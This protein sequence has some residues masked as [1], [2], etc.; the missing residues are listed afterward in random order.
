MITP[1]PIRSGQEQELLQGAVVGLQEEQF[2]LEGFVGIQ[3]SAWKC[4]VFSTSAK[5]IN[6]GNACGSGNWREKT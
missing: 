6:L 2:H 3:M 1:G 5:D 4:L